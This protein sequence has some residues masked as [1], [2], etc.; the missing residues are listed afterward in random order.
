MASG[1]LALV[2]EGDVATLLLDAPPR[3]ETNLALFDELSRLVERVLPSLRVRGL[4]VR[5]RGRHF[6]SGA[7]LDELRRAV[8]DALPASLDEH[9]AALSALEALPYPTVAAVD[10]CCLGSGL[11]LALACRFRVATPRTLFAA[12]E[13][14]FG[15]MPGCGATVRLPA[16]VGTGRA[17]ELMLTG[18]AVEAPEALALGLV[19]A[20]AP[21][22]SLGEAAARLLRA[23]AP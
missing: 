5:G 13:A 12:P 11:E 10:G 4:I 2:E 14:T 17:I 20:V 18:R 16:L 23:V 8:A 15:L 19:D 21:R 9:S 6:S 7:N 3:N 22:E 1:N